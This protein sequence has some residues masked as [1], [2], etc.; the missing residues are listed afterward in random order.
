MEDFLNTQGPQLDYL[1]EV[2]DA[3]TPKQELSDALGREPTD[4][5]LKE[6]TETV[7]DEEMKQSEVVMNE[8]GSEEK[9]LAV[10]EATQELFN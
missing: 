5:E 7:I 1:E 10:E 4:A 3:T 9:R 2:P 6:F 8:P